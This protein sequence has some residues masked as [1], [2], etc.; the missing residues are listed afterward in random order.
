VVL[1]ASA[2]YRAGRLL[3]P[4]AGRADPRGLPR[5][6]GLVAALLATAAASTYYE[7]MHFRFVWGLLALVAAASFADAAR[8]G[9]QRRGARA[10]VGDPP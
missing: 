7:V 3:R 5:P 10:P 4:R 2:A 6:V 1:I 9:P 8:R